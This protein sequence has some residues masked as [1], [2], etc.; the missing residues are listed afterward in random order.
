M[1]AVFGEM[2]DDLSLVKIMI[3]S[4]CGAD[5]GLG[6]KPTQ[7]CRDFFPDHAVFLLFSIKVRGSRLED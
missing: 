1:G 4:V 6:K 2:H 5:D 3:G 7:I